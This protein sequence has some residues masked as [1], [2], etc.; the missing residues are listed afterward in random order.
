MD[1]YAY[2]RKRKFVLLWQ[3]L[4]Q[5]APVLLDE[6]QER[7]PSLGM[8]YISQHLLRGHLDVHRSHT[9]SIKQAIGSWLQFNPSLTGDKGTR[10]FHH[11]DCGRLL[12][13][14]IYDWDDPM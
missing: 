14:V 3:D 10:G 5:M 8:S 2:F 11:P 4:I 7:R 12:C 1:S 13:P 6:I 9:H